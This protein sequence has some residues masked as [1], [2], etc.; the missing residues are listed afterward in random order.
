MGIDHSQALMP[1]APSQE[2]ATLP[3]RSRFAPGQAPAHR[4]RR[5]A[6]RNRA[7]RRSPSGA[8]IQ[9]GIG[10]LAMLSSQARTYRTT[11]IDAT[12]LSVALR[13]PGRFHAAS[14]RQ[15]EHRNG[16][17]APLRGGCPDGYRS[18]PDHP[19]LELRFGRFAMTHIAEGIQAMVFFF[20]GAAGTDAPGLARQGEHRQLVSG[21][22]GSPWA[23]WIGKRGAGAKLLTR[24]TSFQPEYN[25]DLAADDASGTQLLMR[26]RQARRW[27][28]RNVVRQSLA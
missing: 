27:R 8:I 16:R 22:R 20:T 12:K 10:T 21:Y 11:A 6:P 15:S 9:S 7:S 18:Y 5:G 17:I 23:V 25:E 19:T 13:H 4:G 3:L 14:R 26:F 24:T 2:D 28:G 1:G